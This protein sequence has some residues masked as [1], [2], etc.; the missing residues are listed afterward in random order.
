MSAR[1]P[2]RKHA[3][4]PVLRPELPR[5]SRI[6]P[7]LR[8][9]DAARVYSNWGP[10][11]LEL[12]ARLA[13]M[14]GA[15]PTSVVCAN[16]G[17]SALM[18]A[19]LAAAGRARPARPL[20][21]LPDYTFTATGLAA[22]LAGYQPLLVTARRDIWTFSP[23]ELLARPGL[24]DRVGL[25]V[26]VAPYGRPL[27]QA[28]WSRFQQT[29][30]IPVVID[31]AASF[32]SFLLSPPALLG[33]VPV[34]LSFHATKAFATGEGGA[35]VTTDAKLADRVFQSLN[36]GFNGSRS[37][38][39]TGFNGKMSEYAAAVGLAELDGWPGKQ[40]RMARVF[41][42]YRNAFA[43]HG[44]TQPLWG[45]PELSSS[46]ALLECRS[47]REAAAATASLARSGID[48][49]LWYGRGLSDQPAYRGARRVV[50][51]RR[52]DALNAATLLGMPIAPD[53]E[54][55]AIERIA[56]AVVE[57]LAP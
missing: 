44:I 51:H 34:A 26:P 15:P 9:L 31:G 13:S 56:R 25:V 4:I 45:V 55:G 14:F 57:G 12:S 7:Y 43:A 16:S 35:V 42:A 10:L 46:Y 3:P 30:G 32:E 18:G 39:F 53:L 38:E 27:A 2:T 54:H 22:Q 41:G 47:T 37:S 6:L 28:P 8:R 48:T 33:R 19:I 5:A 40:K 24:L 29:T 20:A 50:L 23:A 36:N 52:K 17:T 49:R 11:V 1:R 21:I